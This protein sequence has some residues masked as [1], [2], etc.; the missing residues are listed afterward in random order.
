MFVTY[1]NELQGQ[2]NAPE[3]ARLL[4]KSV[5]VSLCEYSFLIEGVG[6]QDGRIGP[7][8]RHVADVHTLQR[9]QAA[10]EGNLLSIY[11]VQLIAP[12]S[13]NNHG[14]YSMDVL[15]EIRIVPGTE[16]RP[17]YEFLTED[18][19]LYSSARL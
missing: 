7:V 10:E 2:F 19:Q 3:S 9:M 18:G 14:R 4:W 17:V 11:R 6:F 16:E 15:A 5:D 13:M 12:P 8:A 1:Q